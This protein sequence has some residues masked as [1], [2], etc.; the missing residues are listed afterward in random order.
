MRIGNL[1]VGNGHLYFIAEISA[2]HLGDKKLAATLIQECAKSGCHAVKFQT[3]SKDVIA[4]LNVRIPRGIDKKHDLWIDSLKGKDTLQDLLADGGL[5]RE[6]HSELKKVA[7]DCGVDFLSTP[8]SVPDAKFLVEEIGVPAIKIASGDLTFTPLLEYVGKTEIPVII[9]TGASFMYEIV[10][11]VFPHEA[12]LYQ[13]YITEQLA[14][15]HCVSSYPLNPEV[16]NILAIKTLIKQFPQSVIGWSDHTLNIDWLP[17]LALAAGADIYEKHVRH[18]THVGGAD[19]QHS[20]D[21]N[22]LKAMIEN[23]V[24][25]LL[26]LGDGRKIPQAPEL[27]DRLWARRDPTDWLRPTLSARKG[28]WQ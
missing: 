23:I 17:V 10:H 20:I 3:Y 25:A 18:H 2:N 12:P 15:L 13:K 11:Q 4:A 21:T 16:S 19:A 22:Q 8:F 9:S 28:E 1:E 14:I 24:S 7:N 6:Y 26:A 27:H 5:P